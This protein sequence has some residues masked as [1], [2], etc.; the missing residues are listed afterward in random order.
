[1]TRSPT[2]RDYVE[3]LIGLV[4]LLPQML[5]GHLVARGQNFLPELRCP[6]DRLRDRIA[7]R[8][9][10]LSLRSL[11]RRAVAQW[12]AAICF[13]DSPTSESPARRQWSRNVKGWSLAS[14]ASQSESLARSTAIGLRSTP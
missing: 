1:M 6:L 3:G 7:E 4:K 13:F 8:K 10:V 5:V 11:S 12:N 14:V 9:T 2:N